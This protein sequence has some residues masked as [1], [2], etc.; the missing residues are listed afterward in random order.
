MSRFTSV[1]LLVLSLPFV[2]TF[3]ATGQY[4]RLKTLYGIPQ[5]SSV[6]SFIES[7]HTGS[8]QFMTKNLS[9]VIARDQSI[10]RTSYSP[11]KVQCPTTPVVR[12]ANK[13]LGDKERAYITGRRAKTSKALAELLSRNRIPGFD[14]QA[15]SIER[16]NISLSFS[17]GGYRSMLTGAGVL[18][19]YDERSPNS[20]QMHHLG[21]LLQATNYIAGISGGSWLVASSLISDFKPMSI[22]VHE[23]DSGWVTSEPLLEG[24]P[25]FNLESLPSQNILQTNSTTKKPTL[26]I[27][28]TLLNVLSF[29]KSSDSTDDRKPGILENLLRPI[30]YKKP[31]PDR[32]NSITTISSSW[33]KVISFYKDIHVEIESKKKSGF[34]LSITDYWGRALAR[35][36][37]PLNVRSPGVTI[38]SASTLPSFKNFEQPFPI[39][40]AVETVPQTHSSPNYSHTF[41]INPYEFGSWNSYLNAFVDIKYLGTKLRNGI[42][43]SNT[44]CISGYDN[45]GFLTGTSSSMFNNAIVYLYDNVIETRSTTLNAF[46]TILKVFGLGPMNEKSLQKPQDHPD[47]ALIS[48]NP[49]FGL[50]NGMKGTLSTQRNIYLT[51]GGEDGQNIPLH[52]FLQPSRPTDV[53]FA[54]DMSGDFLNFPNGTS[55]VLIGQQ[56]HNNRREVPFYSNKQLNSTINKAIFPFV[57]SCEE[58]VDKGLNKKPIFFGCDLAK[59]YPTVNGISKTSSPEY[60]YPNYTPPLIVY[61]GNT[62]HSFA[63]NTSTFQ[64]SYTRSEMLGMVENGYNLATHKNGTTDPFFATCI[65]CAILKREFDR[66]VSVRSNFTIPTFCKVCYQTY[67]Y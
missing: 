28:Q 4:S 36:I 45:L 18:F 17:G 63:S 55:L 41:E 39:I 12:I 61:T 3:N 13:T 47:Y 48:P 65:N 10:W 21:G 37:F 64:L 49:F 15:I 42:P 54:F 46:S 27:V 26:G 25:S 32:T 60:Y 5:N 6:K 62:N 59:D 16:I 40:C 2:L 23:E 51:D 11:F 52:P 35:R 38:S 24:V 58:F 33:R 50:S 29:Q 66:L 14:S 67:C 43:I 44:S 34:P 30:F 22:V 31:I 8:Y 9:V 56:Y 57:P 7:K 53:I 19:A 1:V 20:T